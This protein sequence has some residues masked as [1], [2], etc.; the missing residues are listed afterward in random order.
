MQI[1]RWI[2]LQ[3]GIANATPRRFKLKLLVYCK[4]W[5]Q[6]ENEKYQH[7]QLFAITNKVLV[8]TIKRVIDQESP[9]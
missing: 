2:A 4:M 5:V 9:P 6:T 3:T 1:A 8:G 7:Q